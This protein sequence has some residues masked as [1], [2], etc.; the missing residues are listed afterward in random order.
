MKSS[1]ESRAGKEEEGERTE[2]EERAPGRL[3][4]RIRA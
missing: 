4:W 3:A 2:R 1:R